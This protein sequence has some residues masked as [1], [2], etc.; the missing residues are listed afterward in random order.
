MSYRM[1]TIEP[2]PF[3]GARWPL[4]AVLEAGGRVTAVVPGPC[5]MGR[6]AR[7]ARII[8]AQL[9]TINHFNRLPSHFGPY[10]TLGEPR[11]LPPD[12]EPVE[13]IKRHV[14]PQ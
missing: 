12:V 5:C 3:S 11:T 9:G 4:G 8:H 13:W 10:I 1:V 14:L 6:D 2:N 7:L